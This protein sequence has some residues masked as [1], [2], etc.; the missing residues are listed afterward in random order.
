MTLHARFPPDEPGVPYSQMNG[1]VLLLTSIHPF[2]QT[3]RVPCQGVQE[4]GGNALRFPHGAVHRGRAWGSRGS[5]DRLLGRRPH[6]AAA[7]AAAVLGGLGQAQQGRGVPGPNKGE[8][9]RRPADRVAP[10]GSGTPELGPVTPDQP[11]VFTV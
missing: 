7:A 2:R 11:T 3:A 6:R 4:A 10:R 8:R 1:S 9:A 5:R